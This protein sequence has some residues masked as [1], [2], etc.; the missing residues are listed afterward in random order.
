MSYIFGVKQNVLDEDE[1]LDIRSKSLVVLASVSRTLLPKVFADNLIDRVDTGSFGHI[2]SAVK[3]THR[4]G[5]TAREL[6]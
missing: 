3:S 4:Q 5:A 1:K 6:I 2:I